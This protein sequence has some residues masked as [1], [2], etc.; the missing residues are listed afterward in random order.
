MGACHAI[1]IPFVFDNLDAPGVDIF[2]GGAGPRDLAASTHAAWVAFAKT[3][4]PNTEG[5]PEWPAYDTDRRATM[6]LDA[7]PQVS[8]DPDGDM[9]RVWDDLI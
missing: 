5:L 7:Q 1:E 4:D 3:G 8:D 2:T 9:R 6:L